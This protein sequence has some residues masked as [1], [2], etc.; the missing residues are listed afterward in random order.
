[1]LLEALL[2][3][4]PSSGPSTLSFLASAVYPQDQARCNLL[5]RHSTTRDD[6]PGMFANESAIIG[7][8]TRCWGAS[9]Q[10]HPSPCSKHPELHPPVSRAEQDKV[11]RAAQSLATPRRIEPRQLRQKN[12]QRLERLEAHINR[13]VSHIPFQH[14]AIADF[15]TGF[16]SRLRHARPPRPNPLRVPSTPRISRLGQYP[17]ARGKVPAPPSVGSHS[18]LKSESSDLFLDLHHSPLAPPFERRRLNCLIT[19]EPLVF[20]TNIF[21]NISS[22]QEQVFGLVPGSSSYLSGSSTPTPTAETQ[23][24][25]YLGGFKNSHTILLGTISSGETIIGLVPGS[26]SSAFAALDTGRDSTA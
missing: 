2:C 12:E 21:G 10:S 11:T 26:S 9:Q 6:V 20:Y 22:A 5:T 4:Y 7:E 15:D 13:Q 18:L 8:I 17:K 16:S 25:N 1:M 23:L 3:L 19:W 14:M 24:L